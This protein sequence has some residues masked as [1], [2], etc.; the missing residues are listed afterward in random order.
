[1]VSAG[2]VMA[3]AVRKKLSYAEYLALERETDQRHEY[4]DGEVWAMAG[5]TLRHS[6]IK[7]NLAG[8]VFIALRGRPCRGYDSDAKTLVEQTGLATYPDLAIVCGR[9]ETAELDRHAATNPTVLFEVLSGRT[10]GWDRGEKFR[11]CRELPS[12]QQYVLVSTTAQVVEVYT[13]GPDD[14]WVLR[15]YRA[16]QQVPL[17]SVEIELSVDELY[18]DLPD[19]PE[20]DSPGS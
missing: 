4:L 14:S 17:T 13:R 8:L 6:A 20:D 5:G 7:Y 9:T 1:M 2:V 11:H 10:E 3:E 16:G 18:V 12:L 19:E 15:T